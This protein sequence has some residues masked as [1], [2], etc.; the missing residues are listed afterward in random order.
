MPIKSRESW[1]VLGLTLL[2]AIPRLWGLG[3]MGLVHFDEGEYALAGLWALDP[4]G[5]AGLD[6]S[7]IAYAPPLYPILAGVAYGLLG[8]TDLAPILV[9]IAAGVA[10]VPAV[11]VLG[12]RAFG[13]GA[14]AGAAALAA[15]SGTHVA[16]SRMGLTDATFLLAWVLALTAGAAF[17]ERPNVIRALMLGVLVGVAQLVKY[18]GWLTGAV[19]ALAAVAGVA[20][21]RDERLRGRLAR[22]FGFGMLAAFA[23]SA[24]YLP[25]FEFVERHGGYASLLSHQRGYFGGLGTWPAFLR[26]QL[27]QVVGL[28]GGSLWMAGAWGLAVVAGRFANGGLTD[29]ARRRSLVLI[30][31]AGLALTAIVPTAGW[32][33]GWIWLAR[34]A[35]TA[36]AAERVVGVGWVVMTILTPMYHPYARLWMPLHAAGWLMSAGLIVEPAAWLAT[37]RPAVGASTFRPRRAIAFVL[38][39]AVLAT[40][41]R[42]WPRPA[43]RA[44]PGLLAPTDSV[45]IAAGEIAAALPKEIR[46][47]RALARPSVLFYLAG[48]VSVDRVGGRD[49]LFRAPDPG[50][51]LLDDRAVE[52]GPRATDASETHAPAFQ[53]V[54][55]FETVLSLPALLDLNPGA[56]R[57]AHS[58]ALATLDVYRALSAVEP[59]ADPLP[60]KPTTR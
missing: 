23:A 51:W 33:L 10:T 55:S 48:R 59:H 6:P 39:I 29:P 30:A 15:F 58:S 54:A 34:R 1:V 45:R 52:P 50:V 32:W 31:P 57:D 20:F 43:A 42:F 35:A 13:P 37:T 56:T 22:I 16:F 49:A 2:A 24:C 53:R 44:L 40:A 60:R 12:R 25:W 8:V 41:Q 28:S 4:R 38:A 3:R 27:D 47:V 5:L 18:N 46:I 9:S 36:R 21:D 26:A 17:L 7:V 11:A 14:G 19:V